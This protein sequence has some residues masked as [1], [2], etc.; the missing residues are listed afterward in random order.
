MLGAAHLSPVFGGV[1]DVV[2]E[3]TDRLDELSSHWWF[4][5]VI[6][7]IA[8]LDSIVPVVPSETA[9]ILGGVAAGQG[10]QQI[11]LVIGAGALGAFLGDLSAYAVGARMRR[12]VARQ[13]ARRPSYQQRLDWAKR[14]IRRRGGALLITA[15]FIPGGRTALTI[16]SGVTHQPLR[17]F[18]GWIA[19]AVVLWASYA[20]LLG[21]VFGN[22]FKDD[23]TTAFLVAFGTA[24]SITLVIEV[25]RHFRERRARTPTEQLAD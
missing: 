18:A 11:A 19:I 3:V 2:N 23:H 10:N 17:W 21:Y 16:S 4:I 9:V 22:T 25:I 13:A 15:R 8:Y 6:F 5:G 14:A 20:G 12:F 1:M 24:L 7:V